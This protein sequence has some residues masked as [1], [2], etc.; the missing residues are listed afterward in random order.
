MAINGAALT[1]TQDAKRKEQ[2]A[3]VRIFLEMCGR[4]QKFPEIIV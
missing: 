1:P 3:G 2:L 4:E